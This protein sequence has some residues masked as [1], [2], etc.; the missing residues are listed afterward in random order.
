[1][2]SH[3]SEKKSNKSSYTGAGTALRLVLALCFFGV[4]TGCGKATSNLDAAYESLANLDYD[5]ALGSLANA[6]NA[7]E[8][9]RQIGRAEG[10][11]YIGKA[12]YSSAVESFIESLHS[13]TGY[14]DDMDIDTNYYLAAAYDSMGDYVSAEDRYNAIIGI[15]DETGC[16][17]LRA[18]VRLKQGNYE[19]ALGDFN[20]VKSRNPNDYDTLINIYEMLSE[21]GYKEAGLEFI[22]SAIN[23]DSGKMTDSERGRMYY[24]MGEYTQAAALLESAR[25][26]DQTVVSS[27]FLGRTYEAMGE[28]NYAANVYESYIGS[29]GASSELY[30]QLGLCRLKMGEYEAALEAFRAGLEADDGSFAK[31]LEYNM[32]VAYEYISDFETARNMLTEYISKYPDDEDAARELEFLATR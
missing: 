16:Y 12:E 3:L 14:P 8:D 19:G 21:S 24:Y 5:G 10:I 1:M 30:D 20:V 2:I 6:E 18:S 15:S 11:A 25:N 29:K 9:P 23:D 17:L 4:L 31:S 22:S 32:A 13:G 27:L 7:G 28:Y 26:A